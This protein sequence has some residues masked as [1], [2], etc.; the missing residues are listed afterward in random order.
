MGEGIQGGGMVSTELSVCCKRCCS[1]RYCYAVS[2]FFFAFFLEEVCIDEDQSFE[3]IL[4]RKVAT[5][6]L[7][8]S[9]LNCENYLAEAGD[10]IH[11]ATNIDMKSVSF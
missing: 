7:T 5:K 4:Q 1:F 8:V 6:Y 9:L 10:Q 3:V 2:S 11:T